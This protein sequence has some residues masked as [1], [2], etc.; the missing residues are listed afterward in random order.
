MFFAGGREYM[1]FRKGRYLVLSYTMSL[2][3]AQI[4]LSQPA[5]VFSNM[6]TIWWYE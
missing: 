2:G 4:D 3:L 5:V 1:T 6:L